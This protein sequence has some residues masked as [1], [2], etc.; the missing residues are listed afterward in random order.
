MSEENKDK[1]KSKLTG[2]YRAKVIENKDPNMFGRV[3]VWIPDVMPK[4]S[5][6][7]GLWALPGNNV[8]SGLNADGDEEHFYSGSCYIPP[9]GSYVW[10]FFENNNP[11]RPY[12][13]GGL[14]LQNTK[15][16]PECQ[17]GSSPQKKW[18]VYK[19]HSGRTIV[20][21][22]D[23]DDERVEITGKKRQ[24]STPPV[25]DT[26]SVYEIN[27]NQ[28]TILVDE[29]DGKEKILIKSHKGDYINF[30]IENQ[31]LQISL[32]SDIHIK[33]NAT[34]YIQSSNDINIKSGAN[35]NLQS[36]GD[37][38][39]KSGGNL[40]CQAGGNINNLAGGPVNLDGSVVNEMTGSA[41]SASPA[42]G[43]TPDGER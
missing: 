43:A 24:I 41:S 40:N 25:G 8:T 7:K 31:K 1:D 23:P 34:I 35:I 16:L 30:D 21:S 27:G 32:T 6:N 39:I 12:Y 37:V 19:S 29:R 5:E 4:V 2:F 18:V 3:M 42:T 14:D 22:D 9:K 36:G 28:T 13:L 11:N 10:V 38:N 26:S 15:V 20:I 17:L 33:S